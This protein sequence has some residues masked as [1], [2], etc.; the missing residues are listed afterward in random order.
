MGG[1]S[2]CTAERHAWDVARPYVAYVA[3]HCRHPEA[4]EDWR[5]YKKRRH[6]HRAPMLRVP[7]LGSIRMVQALQ[8]IGW[9]RWLQAEHAGLP[10]RRSLGNIHRREWVYA[11]TASAVAALYL[12]L[13]NEDGPSARTED[14]AWKAG[15]PPPGAWAGQ[16]IDDPA[17]QPVWIRSD[18]PDRV[19]AEQVALQRAQWASLRP[20][21]QAE[22]YRLARRYGLSQRAMQADWHVSS[23]VLK[24]LD[25]T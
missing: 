3:Y 9:P 22:A 14:L 15:Y 12:R 17:A 6:E 21:E 4:T 11:E 7:A 16:D 8:A 13:Q 19:A 2:S 25:A 10:S 20:D 24:R 1:Q 23:R 18:E 5:L